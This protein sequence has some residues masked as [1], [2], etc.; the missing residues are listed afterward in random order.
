MG[1]SGGIMLSL[2]NPSFSPIPATAIKLRQCCQC[3]R[4]SHAVIPATDKQTERIL[5]AAKLWP[6][7]TIGE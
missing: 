4:C 2:A 7:L 5:P 6:G 1:K 3:R